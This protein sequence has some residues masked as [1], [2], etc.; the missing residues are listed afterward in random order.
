MTEVIVTTDCR[1]HIENIIATQKRQE[2][3]LKCSESIFNQ[4]L[5]GLQAQQ[6]NCLEQCSG[7]VQQMEELKRDHA[8]MTTQVYRDIEKIQSTFERRTNLEELQA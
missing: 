5:N 6:E 7:W 1:K 4:Q 8:R 3:Q 2:E